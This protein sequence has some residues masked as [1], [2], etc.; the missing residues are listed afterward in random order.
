MPHS[1]REEHLDDICARCKKPH[2]NNIILKRSYYTIYEIIICQ[3]CQY[4]ITRVI[5]EKQFIDILRLEN[6]A[7]KKL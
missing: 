1:I 3:N 2:G 7:S 5:P 4:E 6:V